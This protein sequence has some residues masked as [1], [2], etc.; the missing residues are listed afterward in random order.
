MTRRGRRPIGRR[1]GDPS[2]LVVVAAVVAA[3]VFVGAILVM[4]WAAL[5]YGMPMRTEIP[6]P[7]KRDTQHPEVRD[8]AL[9]ARYTTIPD[10]THSAR[11]PQGWLATCYRARFGESPS[12]T[13]TGRT[14][15]DTAAR[16]KPTPD[17]RQAQRAPAVPP[18]DSTH[19]PV[20]PTPFP[21]EARTYE[22]WMHG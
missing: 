18:P 15:V 19:T 13:A 6:G 9:Y 17:R 22:I 21:H 2:L 14:T 5:T 12:E 8:R 20:R 1:P 10:R 7:M 16:S 3:G 4:I 11:L